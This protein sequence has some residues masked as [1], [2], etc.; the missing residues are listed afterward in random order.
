MKLR[1]LRT[2]TNWLVNQSIQSIYSIVPIRDGNGKLNLEEFT[3]MCR[4]CVLH[5]TIH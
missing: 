3:E 2:S 1:K 4:Q 5:F